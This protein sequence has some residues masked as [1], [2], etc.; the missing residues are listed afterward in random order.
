MTRYLILALA[1]IAVSW[2]S[3]LFR[4][5]MAPALVMAAYR[6]G[7]ASLFMAPFARLNRGDSWP[8]G[9]R[10]MA[11]TAASGLLLGLHFATWTTS[12]TL[13]SVASSVVLV[14]TT[15]I[16][17][18]LFSAT[19]LGE[20]AGPKAWGGIVLSVAGSALI[21]WGDS[22][23]MTAAGVPV[24][25]PHEAVLG[26]L[27]ALVGAICAAGYFTLGRRMRAQMR[28]T[29]YLTIVYAIGALT[30]LGGAIA[31]G[32]ALTGYTPR[33]YALFAAM[34]IVPNLIGHSLLNWAVRRMRTYVVNVAILGEAILATVYALA[35]FGERPTALWGAGT[36]MILVGVVG[37]FLSERA[38]KPEGIDAPVE[39][40]A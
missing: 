37:V 18:A 15:P 38:A 21:A 19:I 25:T 2:G 3:I 28:L 26:D 6:M 9:G 33:Q 30:V 12:L 39:P 27:L 5:A 35:L 32:D 34:A 31:R 40:M 11:I 14:T 8:R 13:T 10:A 36:A 17:A 20:R 16:F 29:P 24:H 22:R 1:V 4:L 23:G 7:L